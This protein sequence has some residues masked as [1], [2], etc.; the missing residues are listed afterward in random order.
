M[1]FVSVDALVQYMQ[2]R[3]MRLESIHCIVSNYFFFLSSTNSRLSS[4]TSG[5]V[6]K[7]IS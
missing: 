5:Q 6:S 3:S 7:I 1:H 2:L 4:G